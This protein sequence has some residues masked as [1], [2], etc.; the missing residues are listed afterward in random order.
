[1]TISKRHYENYFRNV[2][3]TGSIEKLKEAAIALASELVLE[4]QY[5]VEK[6]RETQ[7]NLDFHER[8]GFSMSAELTYKDRLV[9]EYEKIVSKEEQESIKR[10]IFSE[11]DR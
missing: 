7:K 9:Q 11:D 10:H 2:A 4:K 8:A 6:Y 1:M 3:A 5:Y